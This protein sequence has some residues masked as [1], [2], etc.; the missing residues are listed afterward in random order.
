MIEWIR[1]T[2]PS[3]VAYAIPNGGYRT[4]AEA[5]RLKWTGV[6]A[7]IPDVGLVL[8]G[9]QA[10]FFEI[11]PSKG[12][13]SEEQEEMLPRLE[14]LGALVAVVRSIDDARAAF[15]AWGIETREAKNGTTHR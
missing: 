7:G 5:A 3:V 14:A 12:Y 10:A 4:K 11:K 15:R 2:C 13:L 6:L 1:W 8:P 9:G